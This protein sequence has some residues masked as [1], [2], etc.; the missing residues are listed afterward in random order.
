MDIKE[1]RRQHLLAAIDEHGSIETLAK[2]TGKNPKH[3]SQI[4]NRRRNAGDRFAREVEQALSLPRGAWDQPIGQA[5]EPGPGYD[6]GNIRP[7]QDDVRRVPVVNYIQAGDPE[8]VV[9][10]YAMGGGMD[11]IGIDEELAAMLGPNAFALVVTG[12]SMAPE[13]RAG[14]IVIVDPAIPHSPGDIVVAKVNGDTEATLKKYRARGHD[15]C[16]EVFELVPIND[17]YATIV[18]DANNPGRIVGPV[19]EHRRRFRRP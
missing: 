12:D 10:A 9:D 18:C 16:G 7:V 14:D 19:I 1:T 6:T 4:K 8:L 11:F 13:I 3:L 17:D 5:S 2:V 15:D